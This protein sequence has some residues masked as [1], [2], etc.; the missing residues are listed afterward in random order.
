MMIEQGK[1]YA[2][3]HNE[4]RRVEIVGK[5]LVRYVRPISG[6]AVNASRDAFEAWAIEEVGGGLLL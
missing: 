2:G 5:T 4:R 6:R 1:T 3:E